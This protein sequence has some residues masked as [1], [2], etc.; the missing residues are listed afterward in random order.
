KVARE[1]DQAKIV[2][3][4]AS[5][6]LEHSPEQSGIKQHLREYLGLKEGAVERIRLLKAKD[7][8]ENYQAQR[9]AL[10]DERLDGVTIAVVPDD[11]WVKGSQPSESSAENQLILIK[12][13]YFEAQENPD[14]IAWLCH[15]LAHCQ[16]FL[17]S[18]SPDEY[19]GNMQRFAFEDLKT[20]YTYP[21]N[22]VEQF[23]FTK[24]FQYLKEHGKSREDVLKMLS[25][26]YNE[27]DFPFFNRL[28][29]SVYGK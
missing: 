6:G 7:L 15:E 14:E 19:Q 5:L 17:D 11:L 22:P 20:E 4:R 16:N 29:D 1:R 18:A 26:D 9:E 10:H 21:N 23:T 28:L 2:D 25:H 8:P 27:E 12:Q 24:Q 13:S 3:V